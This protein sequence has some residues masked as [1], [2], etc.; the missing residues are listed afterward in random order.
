[1][2]SDQLLGFSL[3]HFEDLLQWFVRAAQEVQSEQKYSR[4]VSFFKDLVPPFRPEC[5]RFEPI[6]SRCQQNGKVSTQRFSEWKLREPHQPFFVLVEILLIKL[7]FLSV[8]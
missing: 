5:K 3:Y 7:S 6:A 4:E 2:V 8:K 1:M